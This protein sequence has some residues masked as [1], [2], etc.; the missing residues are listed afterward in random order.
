MSTSALYSLHFH[1]LVTSCSISENDGAR[2]Y[3]RNSCTFFQRAIKLF[4]FKAE[5]PDPDD[6][7]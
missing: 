7:L 3:V 4:V 1:I 6:I 5:L 2:K